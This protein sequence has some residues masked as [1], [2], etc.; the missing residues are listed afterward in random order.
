MSDQAFMIW[1][2]ESCKIE[3]YESQR[4]WHFEATPKQ[5]RV[6]NE[7]DVWLRGGSTTKYLTPY[8]NG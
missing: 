4:V 2:Y 3:R 8:F 1:A 7:L 6:K 5:V